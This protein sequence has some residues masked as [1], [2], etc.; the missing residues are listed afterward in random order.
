MDFTA[1]EFYI[2]KFPTEN[3]GRV[4]SRNQN[5]DSLKGEDYPVTERSVDVQIPGI[6]RKLG[7]SVS[8]IETVR[9]IGYR[10]KGE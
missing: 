5:I 4:F 3:P 6:R 8:M 2:L 7:D 10:M 1:T 9:G